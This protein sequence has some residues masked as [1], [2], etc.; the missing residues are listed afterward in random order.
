MK[1]GKL[2]HDLLSRLLAR[3]PRNPKLLLGPGVGRDAAAID[4]GGGRV[5]VAKADPITFASDQI[6]RYAVHVNA[7]DVA[8]LGATPSWFLATVLLPEGASPELAEEI[9][10][11]IRATC[12]D[13][14]ITPAGGHTEITLGLERPLI[15]GAMLGE[16]TVDALVRPDGA[17][18]GDHVVLT[19][20]IAIEGTA[21]LAREAPDALRAAGVPEALVS[22]AAGLL[23]TPGISI[24]R[25][26]V[27]ACRAAR[28]HALHDPTEGGLSTAL[29]E[30][31]VASG[32]RAHVR[33]NEVPILPETAAICGTLDLDPMGLLASGALLVVVGPDDCDIVR[34]AIVL[35]G[36]AAT[37]IG[38]L[39]SGSG[40][41]IMDSWSQQPLPRFERDELAR[42]YTGLSRQAPR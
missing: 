23:D 17:R 21:V 19:K 15:A 33:R 42:F 9:F 12:A 40:G 13:L 5:L 7:N 27:A 16:T 6:G 28:V 37:C 25:E 1:A 2:P 31:G 24:V 36:I 14:R 32:L 18:A 20:G 39:A 11:Q 4:L 35:K 3:L 29:Q 22:S 41:D 34:E 26:A 38:E 10:E 30:L 8:C